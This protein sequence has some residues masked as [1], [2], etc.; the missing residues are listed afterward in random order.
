MSSKAITVAVGPMTRVT[1]AATLALVAIL[2]LAACTQAPTPTAP[3]VEPEVPRPEGHGER[4]WASDI[5]FE[6]RPSSGLASSGY[7]LLIPMEAHDQWWTALGWGVQPMVD[8]EYLD[9]HVVSP[10]GMYQSAHA[11]VGLDLLDE[12]A[13]FGTVSEV[14]EHGYFLEP[15]EPGLYWACVADEYSGGLWVSGCDIVLLGEHHVVL[16][17]HMGDVT[18]S[19][20]YKD[21]G[22]DRPEGWSNIPGYNASPAPEE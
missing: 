19:S 16:N 17:E 10:Y 9:G 7:V 22:M 14:S 18:A 6:D 5:A 2:A 1:A 21:Y 3:P 4:R 20:E 15:T 13:E 12:V 8:V 11:K